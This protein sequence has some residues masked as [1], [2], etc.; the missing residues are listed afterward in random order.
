MQ[1]HEHSETSLLDNWQHPHKADF[2]INDKKELVYKNPFLKKEFKLGVFNAEELEKTVQQLTDNFNTIHDLFNTIKEKWSTEEN[3]FS[4]RSDIFTL[5]NSIL[6]TPA[7]GEWKEINDFLEQAENSIQKTF[8]EHKK[9]K[10]EIVTKAKELS[11]S[12]EW[13]ETTEAFKNLLEEWKNA[14]ETNKSDHDQLHLQLLE[15][16]NTFFQKRNEVLET[17]HMLNWDKKIEICEKAESLKESTDWRNTTDALQAL[18]DEWKTIGSVTS[19]E[20]NEELWNRFNAARQYFFDRKNEHSKLIKEEQTQNLEKKQ[21]IVEEAEALANSTEWKET[22]SRL[23]QLQIEWDSIGRVPQEYSDE[24]WNRWR[25]AKDTFYEAKKNF[26]KDYLKSL[27][28]NYE[29]KKVLTEKAEELSKSNQ[30]RQATE[31]LSKLLEQWKQIGPVPR[32]YGDDLW[33]RFNEA[34]RLFFQR[35]DE[36][37]EVRKKQFA[38]KAKSRI[39]QTE[40]F[41]TVLN[42]E[43]EDDRAQLAEFTSSLNNIDGNS[44]K[45][46]ELKDHLTHLISK[47]E[48]QITK[49]ISKIT[50]VEKQLEDLKSVKE[51]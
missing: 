32:E 24:L 18:F 37:R 48:K 36:D 23:E 28:D 47:L 20:K 21:R 9:I 8:N 27:Q 25:K 43:L 12:T 45:D 3:T 4:L 2:Y 15:Y 11:T 26:N 6:K 46:V 16:K 14:P 19:H 1:Q 10:E 17:Q 7:I 22:Q 41:L 30:W 50:D 39:S 34:R 13:K 31:E 35:K 42:K 49:R 29:Q 51:D 33:N 40:K 38:E 44:K 5:K